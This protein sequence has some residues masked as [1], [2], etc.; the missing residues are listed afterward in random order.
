MRLLNV[1]L[2]TLVCWL[3]YPYSTTS[4]PSVTPSLHLPLSPP[5]LPPS[6][7][8]SPSPSLPLSPRPRGVCTTINRQQGSR[9][10]QMEP[11]HQ[12]SV[13]TADQ[14]RPPSGTCIHIH[15]HVHM[16]VSNHS[17]TGLVWSTYITHCCISESFVLYQR[18]LTIPVM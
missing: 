11:A 4:P 3:P 12:Q 16:Y 9:T 13:G 1:G 2:G 5:S 8:P 6:H 15:V 18:R 10:D 7:S 14:N 17:H